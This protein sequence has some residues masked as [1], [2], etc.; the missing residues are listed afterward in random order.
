[1]IRL[2]WLCLNFTYFLFQGG[3]CLQIQG[4]AM[5]SPVSPIV[6][7][8]YMESFEQKALV[9]A[10]HRPRWWCWYV[11]GTHT[12][13]KKIISQEFTDHLNSVDDD[14]KWTTEGEVVMKALLEG[15]ATAGEEETSVRVK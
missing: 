14:I 10:P 4:P 6:C 5:G 3:Y 9:T 13:L 15:S 2:L 11:D 8:F 7:N 1:M 12:V